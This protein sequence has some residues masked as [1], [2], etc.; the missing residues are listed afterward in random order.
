MSYMLQESEY[1]PQVRRA[2]VRWTEVNEPYQ[3]HNKQLHE[4]K[5][6]RTIRHPL[7]YIVG[8]LGISQLAREVKKEA[9][10]RKAAE[11]RLQEAV[12]GSHG[13]YASTSIERGGKLPLAISN[14]L[15]LPFITSLGYNLVVGGTLFQFLTYKMDEVV[16]AQSQQG[17]R[18]T[19]IEFQT[20]QMPLSEVTIVTPLDYLMPIR[21][22]GPKIKISPPTTRTSLSRLTHTRH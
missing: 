17:V 6:E 20:P 9:E 1:S 2:Y 16:F 11:N 22:F 15:Q 14:G 19:L 21:N 10:I 3:Q 4:L 18:R 5:A 13:R 8:M 7:A 12:E